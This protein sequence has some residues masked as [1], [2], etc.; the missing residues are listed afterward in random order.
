MYIVKLPAAR[1]I[2]VKATTTMIRHPEPHEIAFR[3]FFGQSVPI[4]GFFG[5]SVT[6]GGGGE[7][8]AAR[9][10]VGQLDS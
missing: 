5:Q 9:S 4:R 10:A 3:G 7:V 2:N 1:R 8:T 6:Y